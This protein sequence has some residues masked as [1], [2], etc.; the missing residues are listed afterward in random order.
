MADA[1]VTEGEEQDAPKKSNKAG[2]I[3]ALVGALVAGGG[4]FA[5]TYMGFL[6]S[7]AGDGGAGKAGDMAKHSYTF[8]PLDPIL[9]TLG[10]SARASAL[11]FTGQLEV[12]PEAEE[13]V[14]TL[15]PRI[16]DVL[17]D[18][19]RA[20]EESEMEDPGALAMLRAQMLR[21]IQVVTGDGMV[22]DLLVTEFVLN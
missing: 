4:G 2:I 3:V 9:V 16:L 14:T 8:V 20:V 18:Y 21:R 17:N 10:P 19:L 6:D 5:A 22:R 15:K 7:V 1:T 11:R 13:V 12:T